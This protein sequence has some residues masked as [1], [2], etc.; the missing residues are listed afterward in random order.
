MEEE[1]K[2]KEEAERR[3]KERVRLQTILKS[4]PKKVFTR[5]RDYTK[6]R[7]KPFGRLPVKITSAFHEGPERDDARVPEEAVL[8][9][10]EAAATKDW[11]RGRPP[12]SVR[13]DGQVR[14]LL[15]HMVS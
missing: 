3:E 6:P 13:V 12:R 9:Q 4:W 15:I 11:R 14:G 1:T 10:T 2:K 7:K 8:Q 5:L